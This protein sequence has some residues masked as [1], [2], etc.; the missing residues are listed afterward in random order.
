MLWM[1][2]LS[3]LTIFFLLLERVDFIFEKYRKFG[4]DPFVNSG[5]T[6]EKKTGGT[7]QNSPANMFVMIFGT[8]LS[9]SNTSCRGIQHILE[10]FS[11]HPDWVTDR[12]L[13][14][15][16]SNM[17]GSDWYLIISQRPETTISQR[18]SIWRQVSWSTAYSLQPA[19]GEG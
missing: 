18:T 16:F 14:V 2:K 3:Q 15:G 4:I 11:L 6:I 13:W 7:G 17:P 9:S 1:A 19:G 5:E 12:S 8:I 10:H